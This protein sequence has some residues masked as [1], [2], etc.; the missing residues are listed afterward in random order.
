MADG[1]KEFTSGHGPEDAVLVGFQQ[2]GATIRLRSRECEARGWLRTG[3]FGEP[4]ADMMMTGVWEFP[5]AK[6][7]YLPVPGSLRIQHICLGT[8]YH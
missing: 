3:L 7:I 4:F 8:H 1:V 6:S 2:D 5:R